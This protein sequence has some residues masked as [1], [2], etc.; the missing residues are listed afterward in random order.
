MS[1]IKQCLDYF[2]N[3]EA[4]ELC[5]ATFDQS[6]QFYNLALDPNAEPTILW[7]GDVEDPFV[8]YPREGLM[9]NVVSDRERIDVFLDKLINMY[10]IDQRKNSP[11][12]TC[13][14]SAMTVCQ[15]LLAK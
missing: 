2:P 14:G 13:M 1:T 10:Q 6:L 12:A 3:P 7:V 5:V 15:K 9:L 4:T 11:I 8:P